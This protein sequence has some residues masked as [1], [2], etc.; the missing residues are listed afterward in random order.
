MLA[1]GTNVVVL[2]QDMAKVFPTSNAVNDALR[3]VV[4]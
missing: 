2:D 3:I 4:A 1:K